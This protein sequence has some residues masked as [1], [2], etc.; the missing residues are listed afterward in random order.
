MFIVLFTVTTFYNQNSIGIRFFMYL[1]EISCTKNQLLIVIIAH[2]FSVPN[3]WQK[4]FKTQ[5]DE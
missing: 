5:L 1:G 3:G 2:C 4:K